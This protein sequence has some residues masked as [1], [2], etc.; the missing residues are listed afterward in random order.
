MLVANKAALVAFPFPNLLLCLQFLTS[1]VVPKA[2]G[3]LGYLEVDPLQLDKVIGFLKAVV[4]FFATLFTS[5][6]ALRDLNVDTV[7]VFRSSLP[8]A[9]ALGDFLF[10]QRELPGA[11]TWA[12]LTLTLGGAA[13]FARAESQLRVAN[14]FWA[15]CYWGCMVADQLVLKHVVSRGPKLTTWGRVYYQN[16]LSLVP[17]V[18]LVL[19]NGE[20]QAWTDSGISLLDPFVLSC[21]GLSC[22]VGCGI[23]FAG[24][25]L[26]KYISALTFTVI[27]VTNKIATVLINVLVWDYHASQSGTL[28]LLVCIGGASIYKQPPKRQASPALPK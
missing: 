22:V 13:A 20:Y 12:A 14:C 18:T 11:R 21:V 6:M 10:M 3:A 24:F 19:A 15:F 2:L 9:V 4:V 23:S 26:R 25:L 7:I 1:V 17:A 5:M 28:A 27:G 8:L 16:T